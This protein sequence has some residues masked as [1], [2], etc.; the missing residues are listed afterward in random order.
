MGVNGGEKTLIQNRKARH[1]YHIIESFEAG[2]VLV[3]TEVKSIRAGRANFKDSYA[4]IVDEEI[5]LVN[6]HI[7]QYEQ[8]NR[9]NHDPTRKRKLLVK[10]KEIGK[11]SAKVLERGFTLVPLR[12]YLKKGL[13]KIEL[14]LAK[15]KKLFD[16]R[17]AIK[18]RDE[19]REIAKVVKDRM[20]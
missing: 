12:L 2:M 3:G 9:F 16:K 19:D 15:G 8:G 6:M 14:G 13:V 4:E 1:L 10:K 7:S 18:K 20:Y 17:E 5:F 11:L